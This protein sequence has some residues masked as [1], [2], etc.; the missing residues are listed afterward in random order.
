MA[1]TAVLFAALILPRVIGT[2][3]AGWY[4]WPGYLWFGVAAY[5]F[6]LLLVLEPVRLVMRS[7]V[8]RAPSAVASGSTA[9]VT[10]QA[11]SDEERAVQLALTRRLF[12]A[13]TGAA[14][15]G[16]A[17]VSLVAVGAANAL[18]PP[19]MLH[20]P[21]RLRHLDPAFNGFRIAVVSDIHL[22][23]LPGRAHTERIV[24]MIN[25][26]AADLVAIVGDLVDGTVEELGPAAEPLRDLRSKE[27]SFFVTGNHEYFVEDTPRGCASWSGSACTCCATRARRSDGAPRR[28]TWRVSTTSPER[29]TRTARTSTARFAGRDPAAR[30]SCSRISR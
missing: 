22:G 21:V 10:V 27:G 1:L 24:R 30:R 18:G 5:L 25:E 4:A 19:E 20:V 12:L 11:C 15:A 28:S 26:T 8:G 17:S 6:L 14:A 13:R 3:E 2:R 16:V 7:W 23:P 29:R 9:T